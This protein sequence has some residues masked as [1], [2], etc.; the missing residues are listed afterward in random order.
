MLASHISSLSKLNPAVLLYRNLLERVR[1]A[2]E[3]TELSSVSSI[4][5]DEECRWPE[6][7]DGNAGDHAVFSGLTILHACDFGSASRNSRC[8]L[9]NLLAGQIFVDDGGDVSRR[10]LL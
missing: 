9:C 5:S 8:F 10:Y 4:A 3:A 6:H 1:L 2:F 7:D